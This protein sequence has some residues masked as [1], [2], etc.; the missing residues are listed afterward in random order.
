MV[1]PVV[2]C[3]TSPPHHIFHCMHFRDNPDSGSLSSLSILKND[4]G[5]E[6]A[7]AL[8]K[9]KHEK[10]MITLC[11]LNGDETELNLSGKINRAADALVLADE[12]KDMGSLSE[13]D[14][15]KNNLR[16]EGLS[17]VSE[18]LKSTSTKQ[19]NIAENMVTYNQQTQKDMSGVI[20]FSED[21]KDMG[22]LSK[23]T[24]SGERWE[25]QNDGYRM[26]D[27]PPVTL[28]TAMTEEDF[29]NKHLGISGAIIL[30]AVLRCKSFR[31]S[32]ALAS[33]DISN[34]SIGSKQKAI[35]KQICTEKPITLTCED[36]ESE[37]E[38]ES[39]SDSDSD[40]D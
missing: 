17:A 14:L 29:S 16:S 12:I 15:S 27:A 40:S 35:I 11:G 31:D 2:F 25:D 36:D 34:N 5:N 6:Q 39:E 23:L 37:S 8:I 20:K 13:L 30:V 18:A 4:I 10:K 21:M 32:G 1:R 19:L 3:T 26:K 9:I 38:S 33:L 24:W 22:S 7:Q 28:D